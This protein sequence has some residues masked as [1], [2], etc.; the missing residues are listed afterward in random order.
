MTHCLGV[1]VGRSRCRGQHGPTDAGD[2]GGECRPSRRMRP[3]APDGWV[4]VARTGVRGKRINLMHLLDDELFGVVLPPAWQTGGKPHAPVQRQRAHGS[5]QHAASA[6]IHVHLRSSAFPLSW[7]PP[8]VRGT[9]QCTCWRGG[10][11]GGRRWMGMRDKPMHLLDGGP[12]GGAISRAYQK[13]EEP[14]APVSRAVAPSSCPSRLRPW[15]A[16]RPKP[17][18]REGPLGSRRRGGS[19]K[20]PMRLSRNVTQARWLEPSSPSLPGAAPVG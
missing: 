11:R 19:G 6:F 8:T 20:D 12:I 1:A 16:S 17:T 18:R 9:T 2:E 14:H 7:L 10:G 15:F 4:G 13:W 5:H 3:G